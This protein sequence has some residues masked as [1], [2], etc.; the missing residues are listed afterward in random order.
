[1]PLKCSFAP[2]TEEA[3]ELAEHMAELLFTCDRPA[4]FDF[5][6]NLL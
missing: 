2:K 4:H 3:P 6:R 1:M 5:S